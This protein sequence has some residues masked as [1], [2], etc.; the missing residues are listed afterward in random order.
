M[1][2]SVPHRGALHRLDALNV[3][4][5]LRRRRPSWPPLESATCSAGGKHRHFSVRELE[6]F[7]EPGFRVERVTRTGLGLEE[8]IYLAALLGR[9]PARRT[10][11]PKPILFLH[12]FVYLLDDA[13]PWGRLGYNLTIRAVRPETPA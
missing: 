9:V 12:L 13:V 8:P 1:I 7:L 11:V 6:A 4:S 10:H 3:Y 2:V 5:A